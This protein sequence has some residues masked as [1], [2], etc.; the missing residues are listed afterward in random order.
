MLEVI[1]LTK[2]D[3]NALILDDISFAVKAGESV[4]ILGA[5]DAGKTAL[6]D[7]LAGYT[8][9]TWGNVTVTVADIDVHGDRKEAAGY[10][11]Y[12]PAQL[13]LYMDMT[14]AEYLLFV[15]NL[16]KART[17]DPGRH[18][19]DVRRRTGFS[20]DC[21]VEIRQLPFEAQRRLGLAQA[22]IG[23]PD[24]LLLDDPFA[25]LDAAQA[26]EMRECLKKLAG[27]H[28]LLMSARQPGDILG[29][30]KRAIIL[31]DCRIFADGPSESLLA[32]PDIALRAGGSQ[33]AVLPL[34][35]RMYAVK[36]AV[37]TGRSEPGSRD[38]V[39]ACHPGSDIRPA[40][41]KVL[42]DAEIPI[43]ALSRRT[44]TLDELIH[45]P[46]EA[47]RSGPKPGG[48][49]AG[50]LPRPSELMKNRNRRAGAPTTDESEGLK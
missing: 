6:F 13:P 21:D 50:N 37:C 14:A 1:E 48:A 42:S 43:L 24:V 45:R 11:G 15:Y 40:L 44:P 19:Y 22:L 3:G 2:I 46:D 26:E 31:D 30:C 33:D 36:E 23:D 7:I 18:I 38:Y 17:A 12:L 49:A 20:D 34:L 5:P 29:V 41:C 39:I 32:A 28:T 35:R 16:K 10:I 9:P 25:G 47:P 8:A 27:S 4:G